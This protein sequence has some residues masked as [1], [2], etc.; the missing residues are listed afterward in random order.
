MGQTESREKNKKM[1]ILIVL[2]LLVTA[3]AISVTVW[4]LFFR[5]T[6]P[7]LSPDYAPVEEEVNAEDIEGET[8]EEKLE[9][10]EGGGAVSMSYQK[11]VTVSLADR[12]AELMF[13]NP[14]R[15]VNDMILQLIIVSA[16]GTE[17]VIAQSGTIHPGKQV[18]K[19]ELID[20]AAELSEGTYSG[21]FNVLYYDPDTGE[22]AIVNG[23]IEGIEITVTA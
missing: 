21:K 22:K 20:G 6:T 19:L 15:S 23:S 1:K 9:A 16:D 8:E 5:D 12:T 10:D 14:S 7:V 17:T 11:T 3:A 13:Q 4:A 2:L 18:E